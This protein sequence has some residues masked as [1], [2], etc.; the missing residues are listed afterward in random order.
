MWYLDNVTVASRKCGILKILR[1]MSN[2]EVFHE[3]L[4]FDL[5]C[6]LKMFLFYCEIVSSYVNI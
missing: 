5:R 2:T 3:M 4:T 6:L 1:L